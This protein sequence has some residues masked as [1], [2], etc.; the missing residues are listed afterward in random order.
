[1]KF[2]I[3]GEGSSDLGTLDSDGSLKKGA[4]TFVIDAIARHK[5]NVE[6]EYYLVTEQGLKKLIKQ[7]KR[8]I[9]GR[10]SNHK[11][12]EKL[13]LSAQYLGNYVTTIYPD[14]DRTGVIF[15]KD[16]DTTNIS[17]QDTWKNIVSAIESGFKKSG[18]KYGVP[19]IPRPKSE[20]WLLGYYQKYL[21]GQNEYNHCERFEQMSGNDASPNSVKKLLGKALQTSD[22]IY[23]MIGEEEINAIDWDRVDMPSFNLFRKRLENV[24]ASMLGQ[25]YLHPLSEAS[26]CLS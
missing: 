8:N 17:P 18:N 9:M 1:M 13:F 19:M 7:D 15:F 24:L 11:P 4:M 25:G 2:L 6:L 5:F 3:S 23:D 14:E 21:Y 10:G 26:I 16:A 20:A 12:Y 22:N